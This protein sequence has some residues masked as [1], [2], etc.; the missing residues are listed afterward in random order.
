MIR[1]ILR[2]PLIININ[3]NSNINIINID[4]SI[5]ATINNKY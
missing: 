2:P 4:N 1:I 5:N 3:S